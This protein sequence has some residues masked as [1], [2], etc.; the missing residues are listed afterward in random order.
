MKRED[1][2]ALVAAV[3]VMSSMIL[4]S[5]DS[6][7]SQTLLSFPLP[8]NL[9]IFAQ[10]VQNFKSFYYAVYPSANGTGESSPYQCLANH[11]EPSVIYGTETQPTEATKTITSSIYLR[12]GQVANLLNTT[13][14][15]PSLTLGKTTRTR[16]SN[17]HLHN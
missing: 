3:V 8:E 6:S 4:T 14:E 10:D 5:C 12:Q 2:S 13:T 1:R 7:N 15:N 17:S 9:N 16:T 11:F